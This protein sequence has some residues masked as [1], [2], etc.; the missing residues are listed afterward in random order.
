MRFSNH[1]KLRA[2]AG[3]ATFFDVPGAN[4]S[5]RHAVA[6]PAPRDGV[7]PAEP[8]SGALPRPSPRFWIVLI[9]FFFFVSAAGGAV[10]QLWTLAAHAEM[11]RSFMHYRFLPEL[12]TLALSIVC[13]L[14]ARTIE[15]WLNRHID[16]ESQPF[17]GASSGS[18][19]N[20][21]SGKGQG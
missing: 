3:A 12:V 11:R 1:W 13:I 20:G 8:E 19:D 4:P 18:A 6:A 2:V 16:E 14:K 15:T 10:A 21:L 7:D 5:R 9:G 17:P